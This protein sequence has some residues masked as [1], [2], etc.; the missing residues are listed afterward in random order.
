MRI[1]VHQKTEP[2]SLTERIYRELRLSIITGKLPGGTRLIES[3]L[4]HEMGASRT[5]IRE[6]LQRLSQEELVYSIPHLGFI[7][8][9]MS[10]ADI[11]DLFATRM[12]IE[13]LV[14]RWALPKITED[15]IDQLKNNLD[16]TDTVI[17][18]DQTDKMI[19]LDIEFH[20]IIY[21]ATRSKSLYQ[22]S[23]NISDH[24]LKF[25]LACIHIPEIAKRARDD[26]RSIY[27]AFKSKDPKKVETAI[28][29]HLMVVKGDIIDFLKRVR[30]EE[31]L[32]QDI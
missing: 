7:V 19:D 15:E 26:H 25:R 30:E 4:A 1:L 17:E 32:A 11:Q 3:T 28:T 31:F 9:D 2:I 5:P 18:N 6:A 23:K 29:D 13:L 27:N 20:H 21:K 16:Q 24:T 8:E 12:E 14:G 22:I 10:E